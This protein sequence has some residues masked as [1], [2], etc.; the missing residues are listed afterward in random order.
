MRTI[1]Q[2]ATVRASPR[3]VYETLMDS[4]RHSRL[5]GAAARISRKVGGTFSAY[6]GSLSGR[7]L[8]LVPGRRIVQ[9]WRGADWPARHH[10]KVT[11]TFARAKSGTRLAL[12]QTGVPDELFGAYRQGWIDYYWTPLRAMF[13]P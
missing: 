4:R 13:A 6:D 2:Q 9:A 11:L 12:R 10:S 7:N 5:T 1:R 3:E 8:A